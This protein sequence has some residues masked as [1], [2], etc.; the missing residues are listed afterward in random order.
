MALAFG[1]GK[2][3]LIII[4]PLIFPVIATELTFVVSVRLMRA[5]PTAPHRH[6]VP[7]F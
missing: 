5:R 4:A 7:L 2:L 3:D 1:P 6:P